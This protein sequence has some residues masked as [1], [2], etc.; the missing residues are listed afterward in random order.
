MNT[1]N[2]IGNL[3]RYIFLLQN[4][5]TKTCISNGCDKPYLG[6]TNSFICYNTRVISLYR[7]DGSLFSVGGNTTF[8]IMDISN[9]TITLLALSNNEN[10][11]S[12]TNQF[13]TI[14]INCIC[15]VRCITDTLVNL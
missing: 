1:N 11:Y 10:I 8:R 5:S 15:A 14:N 6:P 3:L 12:S 13:T 7:K 9:D 2:C 4:N